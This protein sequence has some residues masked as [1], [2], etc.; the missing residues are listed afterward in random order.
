MFLSNHGVDGA[1][2]D[3]NKR[4]YEFL[5]RGI[6]LPGKKKKYPRLLRCR[7]AAFQHFLRCKVNSFG[8][9]KTEL[10]DALIMDL[11]D[12]SLSQY[13]DVRKYAAY[14]APKHL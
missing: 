13:T 10:H 3:N 9:A 11:V 1:V 2:F 8:R 14:H 7:R 4:G 6:A 12:L 5:K